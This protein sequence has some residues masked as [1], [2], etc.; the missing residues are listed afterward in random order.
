M[1]WKLRCLLLFCG[2]ALGF[3]TAEGMLVAMGVSYPL[4]YRSDEFCGTG[5][6]PDFRGWW[7]KEGA[8]AIRINSAGFRDREH[9]LEK[10]DGVIRIAVLG[11]S[12][13][14]SF[15]VA[16]EDMFASV[17][18]RELNSLS[19]DKDRQVEVLSFG[20]SGYGTAQELLMLR[21]HVWKFN[22]DIVLLAFLPSNDL[23]NNSSTLESQT[24]R[25]V[26]ELVDDKLQ[27]DNSFRTEPPY[28][29]AKTNSFRMKMAIINFSRVL[30]VVQSIRTGEFATR[31]A[32]NANAGQT[33][34]RDRIG[35]DDQCFKPPENVE[36]EHAWKLAERLIEEMN[37]EVT[38]RG[39]RFAVTVV[40]SG[41]QVTPNAELR[42]E[43]CKALGVDDL[44]YA[45]NRLKQLG[46]ELEFPVIVLSEVLRQYGQEHALDAHGFSNTSPGEGHWNE[47]GHRE[48]ARHCAREL[49]RTIK[50]TSPLSPTFVGEG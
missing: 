50:P 9:S 6:N 18:E 32:E 29:Y 24:L 46:D 28:L 47:V 26:F 17:L 45:D 3:V 31:R 14:E 36:W 30:Q 42:R 44:N 27:L 7:S 1:S 19:F 20:V 5:L 13:I 35:L 10:P 11:D 2:L 33:T 4:P 37:H 41:V 23:R 48:A 43:Y 49:L 12:Y 21:H 22:P 8:A 25:P 34:I 40:T 15:Q 16:Q 39:A 38:E